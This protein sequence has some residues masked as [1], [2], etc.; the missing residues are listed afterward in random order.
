MWY[1][2]ARFYDLS[3]VYTQVVPSVDCGNPLDF[4]IYQFYDDGFGNE[5]EAPLP[6]EINYSV[7]IAA[8]Y[9]GINIGKCNPIGVDSIYDIDCNDGTLPSQRNWNLRI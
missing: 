3:Y 5:I 2:D 7:D 6:L 8:G 1:D 4:V 9:I